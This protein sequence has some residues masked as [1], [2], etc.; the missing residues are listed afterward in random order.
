MRCRYNRYYLLS[1]ATGTIRKYHFRTY[2]GS[3][4]MP[5]PCVRQARYLAMFSVLWYNYLGR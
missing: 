5:L 2:L 4:R 3:D 1:I